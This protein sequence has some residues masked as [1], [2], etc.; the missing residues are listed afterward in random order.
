MR[1]VWPGRRSLKGCSGIQTA[2]GKGRAAKAR[3]RCKRFSTISAVP[4]PPLHR[5]HDDLPGELTAQADPGM[6]DLA[7]TCGAALQAADHAVLTEAHLSQAV[8][9]VVRSIQLQD[10]DRGSRS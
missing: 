2:G 9:H 7:D 5:L 3:G 4:I 8:A 6:L 10:A 1:P